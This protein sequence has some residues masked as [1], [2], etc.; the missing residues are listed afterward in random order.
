MASWF[1]NIRHFF[2]FFCSVV[3]SLV[4]VSWV[5]HGPLP[6]RM[7]RTF[8]DKNQ[9]ADLDVLMQLCHLAGEKFSGGD[10][11]FFVRFLR[12]LLTCWHLGRAENAIHFVSCHQDR[13]KTVCL[14]VLFVFEWM[15][16]R[17]TKSWSNGRI[18]ASSCSTSRFRHL[19]LSKIQGFVHLRWLHEE[20]SPKTHITIHMFVVWMV[21][22]ISYHCQHS[23]FWIHGMCALRIVFLADM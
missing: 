11:F 15:S 1:F 5:I 19:E 22:V 9:A 7:A 23:Q 3:L 6:S 13:A 4:G 20:L 14:Y 2:C 18:D 17:V 16:L 8:I 21:I 10:L 12:L